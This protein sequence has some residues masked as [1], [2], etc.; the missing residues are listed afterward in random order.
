V[1]SEMPYRIL[2]PLEVERRD[3]DD[4]DDDDDDG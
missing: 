4:D 3:D 1:G 2:L